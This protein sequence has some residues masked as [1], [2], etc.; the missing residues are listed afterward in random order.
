MMSEAYATTSCR[1][2]LALLRDGRV[3]VWRGFGLAFVGRH[4]GSGMCVCFFSPFSFHTN[5]LDTTSC[6]RHCI[7]RLLLGCHIRDGCFNG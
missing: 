1:I 3:R 5:T 6:S 2:A 7:W 4:D